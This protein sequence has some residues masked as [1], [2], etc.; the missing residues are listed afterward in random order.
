MW[1]FHQSKNT[2]THNATADRRGFDFDTNS[3]RTSIIK[4]LNREKLT[5]NFIQCTKSLA[6]KM[7]LLNISTWITGRKITNVLAYMQKKD[8]QG[9]YDRKK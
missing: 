5:E 3:L 7:K 8:K 2:H 6:S 9:N 4:C 1:H